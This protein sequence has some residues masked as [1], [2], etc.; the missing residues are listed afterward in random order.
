MSSRIVKLPTNIAKEV[1]K[2]VFELCDKF[3]YCARGRTDSAKFMNELATNPQ[4]GGV[5]SNFT[6]PEK[7]RT[8]IKDALLNAYSKK[9]VR[10]KEKSIDLKQALSKVYKKRLINILKK[11]K[12]SVWKDEEDSSSVYIVHFGTLLKWE[13]A[14]RKALEYVA[15]TDH[16]REMD[17]QAKICLALVVQ[18]DELTDADKVHIKTALGLIDVKVIFVD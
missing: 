6:T 15:S 11:E 16:I 5:I 12:L 3:D 8:Y 9:H 1:K 7:V 10:D 14:L 13:T 2:R 18:T 4:V 17:F